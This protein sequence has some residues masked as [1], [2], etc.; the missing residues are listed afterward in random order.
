[1]ARRE[2]FATGD[3][4]AADGRHT[5][6]QTPT[7]RRREIDDARRRN[8]NS[9]LEQLARRAPDQRPLADQ[10]A[11]SLGIF[12]ADELELLERLVSV[13][14]CDSTFH[15]AIA[16]LRGIAALVSRLLRGRA[17]YGELSIMSD[18][19]DWALERDEEL[20]DAVVYE[21]MLGLQQQRQGIESDVRIDFGT[22]ALE[23]VGR[24]VQHSTIASRIQSVLDRERPEPFAI[25]P[26]WCLGSALLF[27][28]LA[29][30]I[31]NNT[32]VAVR[33]HQ[34]GREWSLADQ[35]LRLTGSGQYVIPTHKPA[36]DWRSLPPAETE[37]T[38]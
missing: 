27:Q 7:Q 10:I 35:E 34:C 8:L 28:L 21:A 2:K 30:R 9:T 23:N 24:H 1:M 4:A 38:R 19:R 16:G 15:G 26:P 17:S 11:G 18:S 37:P 22:A 33:C 5:L 3:S 14:R 31:E 6:S 29:V 13:V 32:A 12:G 25:P 36:A 20:A